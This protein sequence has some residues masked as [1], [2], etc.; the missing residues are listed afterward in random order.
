MW[1]IKKMV[2]VFSIVW[3][4][5]MLFLMFFLVSLTKVNGEKL[6]LLGYELRPL[7]SNVMEPT[8]RKGSM[9]AAIPVWD[10]TQ[11]TAGDIILFNNKSGQITTSRI[12]DVIVNPQDFILSPGQVLYQMK[13]D[14]QEIAEANIIISGKVISKFTGF[15]IPYAGYVMNVVHESSLYV[16]IIIGF[17]MILMVF[18][19]VYIYK[20]LHNVLKERGVYWKKRVL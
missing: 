12:M 9:I 7:L 5:I 13:G 15:S 18:S 19:V 17:G 1:M 20:V 8:I 14:K 6:E 2:Y 10:R 3:L 11:F 16:L 4:V